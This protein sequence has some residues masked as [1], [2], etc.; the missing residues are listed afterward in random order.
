MARIRVN[1]RFECTG[2]GEQLGSRGQD[3][4]TVPTAEWKVILTS[5]NLLGS[6]VSKTQ[7]S[8]QNKYTHQ[9]WTL[10]ISGEKVSGRK[11]HERPQPDWLLV[12]L[13]IIE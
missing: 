11:S 3:P 7:T 4:S 2:R 13:S 6:S 10:E 9:N 1:Y 12:I 5:N 8:R